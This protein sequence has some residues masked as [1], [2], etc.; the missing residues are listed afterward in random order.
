MYKNTI[1]I[2]SFEFA[3]KFIDITNKYM[4]L[5]ILLTS[6]GYKI[7]AHS[8]MGIFSLDMNKPVLLK[9]SGEGLEDFVKEVEELIG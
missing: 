8:I 7:D 9:A 3:K 5:D 4:G 2:S 6:N 1:T